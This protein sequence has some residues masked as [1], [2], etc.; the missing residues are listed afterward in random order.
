MADITPQ[1]LERIEAIERHLEL[2]PVNDLRSGLGEPSGTLDASGATA[3]KKDLANA[4]GRTVEVPNAAPVPP[5]TG[6][7]PAADTTTADT[8]STSK[9]TKKGL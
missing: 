7:I 9:T 1:I 8:S 6:A 5:D 3:T 2:Q 4:T